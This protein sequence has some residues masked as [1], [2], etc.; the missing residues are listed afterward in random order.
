MEGRGGQEG[1]WGPRLSGAQVGVGR[2]RAAGARRGLLPT[3]KS[4]G[5][6][7]GDGQALGPRLARQG[8]SSDAHRDLTVHV[9]KV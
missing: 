6:I 9:S 8:A 3:S 2:R 5:R 7:S 4:W 1:E